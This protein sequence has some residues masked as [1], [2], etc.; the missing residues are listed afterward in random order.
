MLSEIKRSVQLAENIE[1]SVEYLSKLVRR[2]KNTLYAV[3]SI[4]RRDVS[5]FKISIFYVTCV[6]GYSLIQ[7][8]KDIPVN[9]P[10]VEVYMKFFN[11]A[12]VLE[13][14]T[15]ELDNSLQNA[16][17]EIEKINESINELKKQVKL[18]KG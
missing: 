15:K 8:Y 16:I 5:R 14:I 10:L 11:D 7:C 9:T 1:K 3:D 18:V 4:L 17:E 13:E 6:E 12:S 2:V